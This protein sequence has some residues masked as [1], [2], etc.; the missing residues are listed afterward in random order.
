MKKNYWLCL[1]ALVL[2]VAQGCCSCPCAAK[3]SCNCEDC[4][5][6]CGH[7]CECPSK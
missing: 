2:L 4:L 3:C 7:N 5:K 1:L 6:D